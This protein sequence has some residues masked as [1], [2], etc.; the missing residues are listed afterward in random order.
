MSNGSTRVNATYTT[1]GAVGDYILFSWSSTGSSITGNYTDIS[2]SLVLYSLAYGKIS[3]SASKSWSV[4]VNGSTYSGTN[5]IGIGNNT[6]K[7]LA[8]GSTR[9]YHNTDGSKSFNYSFS[10]TFNITFNSWVGTVSDSGSGTLDMIPRYAS[11]NGFTISDISQTSVSYSWSADYVCSKISC[12]LNGTLQ[13][14]S[15]INSSSGT[16]TAANLSPD[17]TY[18]LYFVITRKDSNLTTQSETKSFTTKPIASLAPG[19]TFSFP[20]GEDLTLA[21][22]NAD[23]NASV[24]KLSVKND[25]GEWISDMAAAEVPAGTSSYTWN[26]SSY[27]DRL[28]E[29]CRAKNIIDIIISCS[30]VLNVETQPQLYTGTAAIVNSDPVFQSCFLVNTEES[31]SS[32]L[33][34]SSTITKYGNFQIQIPPDLKAIPQNAAEII[35]YT[36][37]LT[38]AAEVSEIKRADAAYSSDSQVYLN[39]GTY[40]KPGSYFICVCAVDSRGNT[41]EIVQKSCTILPYHIPTYSIS[42]KRMNGFEK[43]IFLS[44]SAE[45]SRL[46]VESVPKNSIVSLAYRYGAPEDDLS[47]AA[48]TP[49]T[50]FS[51]EIIDADNGRIRYNRNTL[52][53]PFLQLPNDSPFQIEFQIKDR[54]QTLIV[55]LP[56][57]QGVPIM[58]EFDD[59]H[60]TIGMLPDIEEPSLLQINSDILAK[61]IQNT[62]RK[63]FETLS[64]LLCLSAL[65]PSDQIPGGLWLEDVTETYTNGG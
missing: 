31:I 57:E 61:D 30:A 38:P 3:S 43:E 22:Q 5:T 15:V 7:T 6:S 10:Q 27:A 21:F 44:L 50:D 23:M 58:G 19:Q 62:P 1:S 55:Q 45:Y 33:G 20:V 36:A 12:Y 35:G 9:I 13:G 8:S 34:T 41:S 52:A 17:T 39:L 42:P 40:D 47:A 60:I 59:G 25:A 14:S 26:L 29:A 28:Y 18:S 65:E 46:L 4:N 53:A 2:W 24:L 56:I 54:I 63:I 49:I 16:Y 51:T 37:Y 32:L 64:N 48:W 11:V